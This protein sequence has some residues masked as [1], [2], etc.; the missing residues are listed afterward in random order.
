MVKKMLQSASG[1]GTP[2]CYS[3]NSPFS[4]RRR[5]SGSRIPRPT[6]SAA[7]HL[8]DF[9]LSDL[10][11]CDLSDISDT[12]PPGSPNVDERPL[13][14]TAIPLPLRQEE[15]RRRLP[16]E[17]QATGQAASVRLVNVSR[18]NSR[19]SNAESTWD[20]SH[21]NHQAPTELSTISENSRFS[22]TTVSDYHSVVQSDRPILRVSL[23]AEKIIMG[24]K[25]RSKSLP[26]ITEERR[27]RGI[28]RPRIIRNIS[29]RDTSS[30]I[31][32]KPDEG[33]LELQH[34]NYYDTFFPTERVD[35]SHS[36]MESLNG[37]FIK[38]GSAS[39][40]ISYG[41]QN[42]TAYSTPAFPPRTSSLNALSSLNSS[43]EKSTAWSKIT[44]VKS[45]GTLRAAENVTFLDICQS[46]PEVAGNIIQTGIVINP[47]GSKIIQPEKRT[48]K[49]PA[50]RMSR[51]MGGIRNAF[52]RSRSEKR[53]KPGLTFEMVNNTIPTSRPVP[54]TPTTSEN[55]SPKKSS[56]IRVFG[57]QVL[58][59]HRSGQFGELETKGLDSVRQT[60]NGLGR[61]LVEDDNI[62]RRR[63]W[64][65]QFIRLYSLLAD[66]NSRDLRIGE[67]ASLVAQM[68]A[69]ASLRRYAMILQVHQISQDHDAFYA[70]DLPSDQ[71]VE[72]WEHTSR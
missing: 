48:L 46:H 25:A 43:P 66:F 7:A 41:T 17:N 62:E 6:T 39:G 42:G 38:H 34:D 18:G 3:P 15:N 28:F 54:Q 35:T 19:A 52:S 23:S 58:P 53:S 26:N 67:A 11:D 47:D 45:S 56:K 59:S 40:T 12:S 21:G 49:T 30:K 31:F 44:T 37:D 8:D 22:T 2:S 10:E 72:D 4:L 27:S 16:L 20:I 64:Y 14:K 29:P 61:L 70:A 71:I 63:V 60:L 13:L 51:V 65:R 36:P 55:G 50:P 57:P 24:D 69:E 9:A 1:R 32:S 5:D 33:K 68:R